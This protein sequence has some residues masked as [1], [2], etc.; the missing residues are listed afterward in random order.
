MKR[1]WLPFAHAAFL[2]IEFMFLKGNLMVRPSRARF[3]GRRHPQRMSTIQE[4]TMKKLITAAVLATALAFPALAQSDPNL[5][6][7]N[8]ASPLSAPA[9][10]TV[11]HASSALASGGGGTLLWDGTVRHDPDANIQFQLNREAEQGEW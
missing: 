5:G 7:G 8:I 11:R 6:L 9:P 1:S 4:T 2:K 3:A 10:R